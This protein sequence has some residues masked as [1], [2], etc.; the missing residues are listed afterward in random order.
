MVFTVLSLGRTDQGLV[1][2]TGGRER[3]AHSGRREAGGV[4]GGRRARRSGRNLEALLPGA[5]FQ[6]PSRRESVTHVAS[7]SPSPRTAHVRRDAATSDTSG[8]PWEGEV[9]RLVFLF[10]CFRLITMGR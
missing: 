7:P 1:G 4:S 3:S 5:S 8:I 2:F 10:N 9:P 6:A